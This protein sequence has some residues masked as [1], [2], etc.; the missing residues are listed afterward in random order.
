MQQY[1]KQTDL[2]TYDNKSYNPGKNGLIRILWYF[3]NVLFFLNPLNPLSSLKVFLLRL[4]G[5]KVGKGVVIK[6]SVNIK[7]PW[8]LKIGNHSW[9][10]EKVWIDNL[11]DVEIGDNCC[12]SQGAM[13][14]T[15]SH[16]YTKSTFNNITGVITLENGVWIGTQAVVYPDIR[17]KSHSILGVNS[18][19]MKDL[20]EYSIYHGN[21]AVKISK[22]EIIIDE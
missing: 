6:P 5:A 14:L 22:R 13:L 1:I 10:G 2:S 21:P 12:L 18:V 4:F 11:A 15:G 8:H 19:A 20:E 17:C 16:D 3:T 7:Y 9:I